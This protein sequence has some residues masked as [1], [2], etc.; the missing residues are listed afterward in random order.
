VFVAAS[1]L[2]IALFVTLCNIQNCTKSAAITCAQ[3][4]SEDN[5]VKAAFWQKTASR[6]AGVCLQDLQL[7]LLN[8]H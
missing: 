3:G 2:S 7:L 5:Y 6:A 4:M 1:H 8:R